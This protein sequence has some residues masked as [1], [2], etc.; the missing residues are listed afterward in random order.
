LNLI[1]EILLTAPVLLFS[2]VAHEY[3]H[4]YAAMKQGDMTA[5][6]LGRLTFNPAKHIDPFMTVILPIMLAVAHMPIFG[7]AK[8]V[9]VNPNNYRNYRMGDIIVSLAG[10]VTNFAIAILCIP[11]LIVVGLVGQ[12]VSFLSEP[13]AILQLMLERG[14][15]INLLLAVFNLL[16]I[17][18]LDGSHVFKY[19]LPGK[20]AAL[21]ER[22]SSAGFLI[23]FAL[24][25]WG[26][27]VL[28]F[29][30]T[31]VF[32]LSQRFQGFYIPF[33]LPNPFPQ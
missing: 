27:S 2:M 24:L 5:S 32:L 12:Q 25:Y 14:L 30:F 3:A 9:P 15:F 6:E 7:G 4:G 18:P 29:W 13:L 10:I 16:P 21:Y 19:L 22:V 23:L 1:Q 33:M 20:L 11:L 31:P 26:Q 17:P 8:P 28:N